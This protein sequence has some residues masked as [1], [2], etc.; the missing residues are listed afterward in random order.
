MRDNHL[1]SRKE[2]AEKLNVSEATLVR[3]GK[4]T[5]IPHYRISNLIRFDMDE[6]KDF[7]RMQASNRVQS[8][9]S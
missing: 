9:Q 5:D 6:V 7:L 4:K 1:Y 3:L 2:I 8:I